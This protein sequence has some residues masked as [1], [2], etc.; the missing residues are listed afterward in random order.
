MGAFFICEF[1]VKSAYMEHTPKR[2]VANTLIFTGA[3]V[4]QKIIAFSYFWFLSSRLGPEQLGTY[5]WALSIT[6]MFSVGIDLGLSPLL[7]RETSR[8]PD[9]SERLLRGVIALKILFALGTLALLSVVM[10]FT[11]RDSITLTVVAIAA[12]VMLFDSFAMSFWGILR[13]RQKIHFESFGLLFFHIFIFGLG[14]YLLGIANS[15]IFAII[16]LAAG[17]FVVLA[18]AWAIVRFRFGI[19]TAPL[20]D[21]STLHSLLRLLPAFAIAGIFMRLYNAADIVLLGYLVSNE[22]VGLYSIPVK[23]II[24]LQ[25]LIPGAFL[26]SIYPAM[27]FYFTESRQKLE[28]LFERSIGYLA[29]LALP[30]T[31]ALLVLVPR[32]L[33]VIWPEYLAITNT[34]LLMALGLP[35]LFFSFPTGYLLNAAN[36][37][38]QNTTNRGIITAINIVLNISLIPYLGVFGAGIAF[39]TSNVLLFFLDFRRVRQVVP[40]VWGWLNRIFLKSGVA[41]IVMAGILFW[42]RDSLSL[43]FLVPL[44]MVVYLVVIL[45][46]RTF[47]RQEV[48]LVREVFRKGVEPGPTTEV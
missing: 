32:I 4:I 5:I 3:M 38:R 48:A 37:Q 16:A 6:A 44:G 22:A 19:R 15:P 12:L 24:A 47:T 42:L 17:S 7:I 14:I 25:M 28:Q 11:G 21:H 27:S 30:I 39:S 41:S 26:A 1:L 36:R 46:L 2:I 45:V 35:F 29:V 40:V 9:K 10:F 23:V 18:L 13:S 20:F 34:F 33:E 43:L 31:A 8:D